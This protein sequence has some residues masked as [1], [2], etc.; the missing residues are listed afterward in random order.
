MQKYIL[1]TWNQCNQFYGIDALKSL[2]LYLRFINTD[3]F[4]NFIQE[5]IRNN[6]FFPDSPFKVKRGDLTE[7]FN[8]SHD[9]VEGELTIG[10]Q[11]HFYLE[12]HSCVVNPKNEDSEIEIYTSSQHPTELQVSIRFNHDLR[13]LI[14]II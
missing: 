1:F 11:E 13:L 3:F 14:I 12:T 2:N 8:S 10:G 5:A 6:S 4:F 7:N 9:I